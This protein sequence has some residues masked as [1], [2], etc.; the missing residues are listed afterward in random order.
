M[1]KF[2]GPPLSKILRMLLDLP[3]LRSELWLKPR[4]LYPRLIVSTRDGTGQDFLNPTRPVNFKII[5][6]WPV[7]DR[8]GRPVFLPKVHC[9]MYQMKNFQKRGGMGEV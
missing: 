1:F 4:P 3:N 5:A 6:G 8:P 9:S 7:S 2:R